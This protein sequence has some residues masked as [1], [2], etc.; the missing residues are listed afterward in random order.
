MGSTYKAMT[1]EHLGSIATDQDL[2]DFREA[3]ELWSYRPERGK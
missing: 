2:T 3:C 1:V